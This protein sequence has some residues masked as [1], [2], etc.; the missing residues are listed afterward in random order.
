MADQPV[1]VQ[2]G[3][4]LSALSQAEEHAH[5]AAQGIAKIQDTATQMTSGAWLGS[6][7]SKFAQQVQMIHDDLLDQNNKLLALIDGGRGA[8]NAH[9]QFDA[10]A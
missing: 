10:E 7:A 8:V 5:Q 2:H 9:A 1:R 4:A 6:A 3:D